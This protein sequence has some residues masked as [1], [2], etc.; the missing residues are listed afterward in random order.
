[1][2]VASILLSFVIK[3]LKTLYKAIMLNI[4]I[5]PIT[6]N[7]FKN[8][9]YY[10]S[11]KKNLFIY[12]IAKRKIIIFNRPH[13]TFFYVIY[14]QIE[15]QTDPEEPTATHEQQGPFN[16]PFEKPRLGR[17]QRYHPGPALV[18]KLG[19]VGYAVPDFDN[20]LVWYACN[21]NFVPSDILDHWDFSN[22]D[23][24]TFMHLDLGDEYSDH[25]CFFMQRAEPEIKKTY[26]HHTSFEVVDFNTQLLGH[27]WLTKKGWKSIWGVGR[28]IEHYADG[29]VVNRQTASK[30]DIVGPFSV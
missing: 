13:N 12:I 20:E 23:V 27:E 24:L 26:C 14:S 19:H 1:M 15:R 10:Y 17:F 25:H 3:L 6:N 22:M 9:I 21:F 29:D 16:T 5:P 11:H 7:L 18:H 8:T 2:E 30:R 28:H 4:Y